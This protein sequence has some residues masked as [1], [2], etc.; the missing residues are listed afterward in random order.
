MPWFWSDQFDIKLQMAGL[1]L[2]GDTELVRGDPCSGR[3][4]VIY[5]NAN[6]LTAIQCVNASADFAAAKKMIAE[7][8]RFAP[9]LLCDPLVSLRDVRLSRMVDEPI[10]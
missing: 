4:S 5:Q 2:P 9:A 7:R 3:F 10:R 8:R 6:R 1:S